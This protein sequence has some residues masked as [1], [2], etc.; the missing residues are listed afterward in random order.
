MR[1]LQPRRTFPWIS[2]L[3]L[4]MAGFSPVSAGESPIQESGRPRGAAT[5]RPVVEVFLPDAADRSLDQAFAPALSIAYEAYADI[6]VRVIWRIGKKPPSGC[7]KK[8]G[9]RQI[10]FEFRYGTVKGA[11]ADA[12]A[13]AKP[14]LHEG[15]CVT[16]LIERLKERVERNPNTTGVLLGHV[17]A[18]EI[19]H[20]L[21]GSA[22]HSETGLMKGR[23]SIREIMEM[24]RARLCFT[25]YDA[26]LIL[27]SLKTPPISGH[28]ELVDTGHR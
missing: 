9:A 12:I 8:P 15:P 25:A 22:R 23:W 11:S 19:G 14:F 1:F 24:R 17:L 3:I 4:T 26:E 7:E 5:N 6:G 10:V 27:D 18:H 20:V 21:Q 16:L 13:F 28:Q 2:P